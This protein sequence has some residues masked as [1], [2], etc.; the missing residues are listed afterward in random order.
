MARRKT[1]NR[2]RRMAVVV[3]GYTVMQP[4]Y[5]RVLHTEN[6]N[7]VGYWTLRESSGSTAVDESGNGCDGTYNSPTLGQPGIGDGWTVPLFEEA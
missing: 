1:R 6:D 5:R 7:L 4:Y 3:E 2:L